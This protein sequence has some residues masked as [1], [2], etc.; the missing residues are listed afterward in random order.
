MEKG[1]ENR[2]AEIIGAS[3][4]IWKSVDN[5]VI[6]IAVVRK[7]AVAA[8]FIMGSFFLDISRSR[9]PSST[10][11]TRPKVPNSSR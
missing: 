8:F 1:I 9:D 2:I 6:E 7:L 3:N 5:P 10:I 11:I 4:T